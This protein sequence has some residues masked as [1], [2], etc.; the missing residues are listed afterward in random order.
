MIRVAR[1]RVEFMLVTLAMAVTVAG[2]GSSF[3]P[4]TEWRLQ[5]L[6]ANKIRAYNLP[7]A[8]VGVWV[9]GKGSWTIAAGKADAVANRDLTVDDLFR[10]GSITKTFTATLILQLAE[11]GLIGLDDALDGYLAEVEYDGAIHT[12]PNAAQ[13]T[14]RQLCNHTSGINDYTGSPDFWPAVVEEPERHRTPEELVA[15]AIGMGPLFEPGAAYGY[16]NT[17]YVLLGMIIEQV[18]GAPLASELGRRILTPLGL[19]HTGLPDGSGVEGSLAHGYVYTDSGTLA[20]EMTFFDTSTT[21][22]AGGMVSNLADLKVWAEAL[23]N[24]SLLS[25]TS[26]AQQLTCVNT[27]AGG[28]SSRYGLGVAYTDSL[29]GHTGSLP[30]YNCAMYHLADNDATIIVLL[31]GTRTVGGA[32]AVDDFVL[33]IAKIVMPLEV[34]L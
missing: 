6:V 31:N 29:L 33:S 15:L 10:V 20:F 19:T 34:Y 9:P 1:R 25:A 3:G 2:C 22:S 16:S 5:Q 27:G 28:D 14:I 23:A 12:I 26:H 4:M 21:W 11:E 8:V 32:T 24:G 7:G 13:I 30:S 18:T 17:N